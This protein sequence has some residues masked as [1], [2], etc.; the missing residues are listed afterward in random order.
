VRLKTWTYLQLDLPHIMHDASRALDGHPINDTVHCDQ[1][2]CSWNNKVD[3]LLSRIQTQG[4]RTSAQTQRPAVTELT[5]QTYLQARSV[6]RK[7]RVEVCK[8][9][10]RSR[11]AERLGPMLSI[12][13]TLPTPTHKIDEAL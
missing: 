5:I 9:R 3:R 2:P 8:R 7:D 4:L 12:V 6:I 11:L 10:H 13:L 1:P